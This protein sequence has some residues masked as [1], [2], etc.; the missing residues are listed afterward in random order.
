MNRILTFLILCVLSFDISAQ[1]IPE[2]PNAYDLD[3][4][5]TGAWTILYDNDW[6]ITEISDSVE[7]YRIITYERGAPSGKVVDYEVSGLKMW[8]GFLYS[9]SPIREYS[10]RNTWFFDDGS[11]LETAFFKDSVLDGENVVYNKNGDTCFI[12]NYS[13]GVIFL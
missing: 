13:Q 3:S 6:N 4:N 11:I 2:N 10:G 9:E 8:E 1:E 5:K 7:Y 12:I